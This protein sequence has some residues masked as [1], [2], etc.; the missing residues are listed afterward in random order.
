MSDLPSVSAEEVFFQVKLSGQL[1]AIR[2]KIASQKIILEAA[3]GA[4]I[5]VAPE[6][7]QLS[8]NQFR[9]ANNLLRAEDT[10]I[11][12][13]H[14]GLSLENFE[15]MIYNSVL[16]FK[17]SEHLFA[18]K[19]ESYFMTHQTEYTSVVLYEILLEDED[20]ALEL[21]YRIKEGELTFFEVSQ[22]Y[23]Q[24]LE[25][26]RCGGYRGQLKRSELSPE[27]SS[28]VFACNPPQLLKPVLTAN[29]IHLL[30]IEEIIQAELNEHIK[31]NI[32][33]VL[34]SEWLKKKLY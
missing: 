25:L 5:D 19:L 9:K 20:T 6:E 29:G 7:I 31:H 15:T 10:L 27:V 28:A 14:T 2:E 3:I 21:F 1:P 13:Q 33:S 23:T 12:L 34:F 11:W 26:K 30:Y 18:N 16:R 4:G 32:T 22:N 17:L 8:A 24:D